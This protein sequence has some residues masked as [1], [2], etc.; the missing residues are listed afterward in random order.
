[1]KKYQFNK[2][3]VKVCTFIKMF[4]LNADKQ[5]KFMSPQTANKVGFITYVTTA[6]SISKH[7][8]LINT[9]QI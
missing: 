9:F 3:Y 5:K 7:I 1:M 8:W 4:G 2:K 6:F